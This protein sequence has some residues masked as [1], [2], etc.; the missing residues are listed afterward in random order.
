MSVLDKE[1]EMTVRPHVNNDGSIVSNV[2]MQIFKI[3][4]GI[5]KLP[6]P[7]QDLFV[8]LDMNR[9][10]LHMPVENSFDLSGSTSLK[11]RIVVFIKE[12]LSLFANVK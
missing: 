10:K 12:V 1:L 7:I 5:A 11:R 6:N 2:V 4:L 3:L 8:E 9:F